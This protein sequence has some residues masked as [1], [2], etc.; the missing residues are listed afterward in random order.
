MENYGILNAPMWSKYASN[1]L[2]VLYLNTLDILSRIVFKINLKI[3][4]FLWVL[5]FNLGFEN[6]RCDMRYTGYA[7]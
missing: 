4:Y 2:V 7:K 1:R 6:V 5:P 3:A